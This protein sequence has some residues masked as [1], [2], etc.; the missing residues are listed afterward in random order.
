MYRASSLTA[1]LVA[2]LLAASGAQAQTDGE[3]LLKV[4]VNEVAYTDYYPAYDCPAGS[5]CIVFNTWFRYR[6]RVLEV[7]RGDY[8]QRTVTFARLQHAH[9]TRRPRNWYVLLVPCGQS[10]RDAVGVEYC[11]KDDTFEPLDLDRIGVGHGA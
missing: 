11:V 1:A 8:S 7:V 9:Y 10:V 5:E 3:V 2:F 4:R 6:A